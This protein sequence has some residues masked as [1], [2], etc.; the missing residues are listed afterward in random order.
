MA[1]EIVLIKA[2]NGL[3][4]ATDRDREAALNWKLGQA[5]KVKAVKQS[6]RTLPLH[7]KYWAG[8][9]ALTFEYWEP[10]SGMT[11]Q[12]ERKLITEFCKV[13]DSKGGNGTIMPIG[14]QFLNSLS[15]HRAQKTQAP[16]KTKE[17]LHDW[18]KERAGYFDV[19][20]TPTGMKRKLKSI[21]FN[22]MSE[23]EFKAYYSAAFSV[24]WRYVLGLTFED[25]TTA[26]NAIHQLLSV[27]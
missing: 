19:E 17:A 10:D 13:L 8:L 20:L 25:E 12:A 21:N 6:A 16:T 4:Y 27:N 11:T 3:V 26:H 22:A 5:V 23:E 14:D 7:Q 24:C 2:S 1:N 9:I 15:Q 18:I